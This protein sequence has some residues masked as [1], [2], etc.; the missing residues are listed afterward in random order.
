M[1]YHAWRSPSVKTLQYM[2][3]LT[4]E[5]AKEVKAVLTG[6]KDVLSYPSVQAR[7]AECYNEPDK[8]YLVLHAVNEIIG[9][10]GVGYIP[11]HNSFNEGVEYVNRGDAYIP[12][13]LYDQ[14]T[15]TWSA[16]SWGD[17]VEGQPSRFRD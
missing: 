17:R 2:L 1:R 7:R 11:A 8:E 14:K 3:N 16:G 9:G 13:I 4:E 12:T 5:K 10:F 15:T 6:K